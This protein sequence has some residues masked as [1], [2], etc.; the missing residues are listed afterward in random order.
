MPAAVAFNRTVCRYLMLTSRIEALSPRQEANL[1]RLG[2][3]P[4][5]WLLYLL[6][7]S[8]LPLV[9]VKQLSTLHISHYTQEA[10][11]LEPSVSMSGGSE[12][13]VS[14]IARTAT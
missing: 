3:A 11:G 5:P 2:G 4:E 9:D 6:T 8:P 13:P 14:S 7:I 1:V 10:C 12:T